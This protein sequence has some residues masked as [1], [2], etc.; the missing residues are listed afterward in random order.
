MPRAL[1]AIYEKRRKE[2]CVTMGVFSAKTA[3]AQWFVGNRKGG[4]IDPN[5]P[6]TPRERE[7]N[8]GDT[9]NRE[10][11]QLSAVRL[12]SNSSFFLSS[13]LSC[14]IGSLHQKKER[15]SLCRRLASNAERF[16]A[17]QRDVGVFCLFTMR[18]EP[19]FQILVCDT[20]GRPL[21]VVTWDPP[22]RRRALGLHPKLLQ[23]LFVVD[24]LPLLEDVSSTSYKLLDSLRF[25][26]TNGSFCSKR[27]ERDQ[28]ND[29]SLF[30][31]L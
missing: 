3:S 17:R 25:R 26:G 1:R 10:C 5:A 29:R 7:E 30:F 28:P 4:R 21:T 31:F 15:W 24:K 2:T 6:T 11:F 9:H 16:C 27:V 18:K 13:S 20:C 23:S 19:K 12:R 22:R 14:I 8:A